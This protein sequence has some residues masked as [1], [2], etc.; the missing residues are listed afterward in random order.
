VP[1][2]CFLSHSHR[3]KPFADRLAD[4][5]AAHGVETG[6][7]VRVVKIIDSPPITIIDGNR[8]IGWMC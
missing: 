6:Y 3:D 7:R 1:I 8:V 4:S 2:N 5:L